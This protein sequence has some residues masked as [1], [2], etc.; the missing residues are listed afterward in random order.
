[1]LVPVNIYYRWLWADAVK[2]EYTVI[3]RVSRL[4]TWVTYVFQHI[5]G[6]QID[7]NW[8]YGA[9]RTP[10]H[11]FFSFWARRLIFLPFY[12]HMY[13][14]SHLIFFQNRISE[15]WI[16]NKNVIFFK[17]KNSKKCFFCDNFFFFH[18]GAIA[19][20]MVSCCTEDFE[21]SKLAA[22]FFSDF[23]SLRHLLP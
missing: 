4:K 15:K 6:W 3:S 13:V 1:M 23:F 21:F 12:C 10:P 16:K 11:V 5:L 7:W 22:D 8:Y 19:I 18:S 2:T 14:I 20:G 9:L 17:N